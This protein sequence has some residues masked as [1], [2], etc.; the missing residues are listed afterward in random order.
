MT[1][2]DSENVVV[3]TGPAAPRP[4]LHHLRA[5]R[6]RE[7]V[8]LRNV[9]RHL[10]VSLD[11]VK[12]QEDETADLPLSGQPLRIDPALVDAQLAALKAQ[13]RGIN[14]DTNGPPTAKG[15]SN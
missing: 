10:H 15:T 7:R 2:V 6:H 8:S 3:S 9:A 4:I 14:R 1:A 5:V 11:D 12:A 13:A